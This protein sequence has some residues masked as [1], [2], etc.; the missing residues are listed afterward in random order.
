MRLTRSLPTRLLDRGPGDREVSATASVTPRS[1]PRSRA[2]VRFL[3]PVK[4]GRELATER[5][6]ALKAL[7]GLAFRS[8][9]GSW[10]SREAPGSRFE[11][12]AAED[13]LPSIRLPDVDRSRSRSAWPL[14]RARPAP[15]RLAR[16]ECRR[17]PGRLGAPHGRLAPRCGEDDYLVDLPAIDRA[18]PRLAAPKQAP[19]NAPARHC[20]RR[21]HGRPPRR[22]GRPN[23]QFRPA[24][25][26]LAGARTWATWHPERKPPGRWPQGFPRCTDHR[27][28]RH[29]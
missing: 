22:S 16:G 29:G 19:R 14:K 20:P 1:L 28:V 25:P 11:M 10:W 23:A 18:N 6:E 3:D 21:S 27:R 24:P 26:A 15:S 8:P 2:G 12:A 4:R 7:K 17:S 13:V 9:R 5:R